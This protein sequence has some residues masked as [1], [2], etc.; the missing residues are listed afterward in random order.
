MFQGLLDCYVLAP[1]RTASVATRFLDRFLPCR[2][3]SWDPDDPADSLGISPGHRFSELLE[4]LESQPTAEYTMYLRN[5][6]SQQ[7]G[8]AMLVWC[9]D[10]SLILGL[11]TAASGSGLLAELESFTGQRGYCGGEEP[12][13]ASSAEFRSRQASFRRDQW[14]GCEEK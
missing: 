3:E 1:E 7:P 10:G 4:F 6:Q 5:T 11:S 8:H 2:E 9:S 14:Q 12:P 13:V